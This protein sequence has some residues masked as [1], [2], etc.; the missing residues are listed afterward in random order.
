MILRK[1]SSSS[2]I[3]RS[4]IPIVI[5][6]ITRRSSLSAVRMAPIFNYP[7]APRQD[8]KET[9]FGKEVSIVLLLL[10]VI[11]SQYTIAKINFVSDF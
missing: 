11:K 9:F 10:I 1:L 5:K 6:S 4:S 7:V 3:L 2:K 8:I